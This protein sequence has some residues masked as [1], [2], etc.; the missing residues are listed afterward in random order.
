MRNHKRATL[1]RALQAIILSSKSH[2]F[3]L[4]P[5]VLQNR[6]EIELLDDPIAF[7]NLLT[8][9]FSCCFQL[10]GSN[11]FSSMGVNQSFE[12]TS[13]TSFLIPSS[14]SFTRLM[15]RIHAFPINGKSFT[16]R[17]RSRR[18]LITLLR[19]ETPFLVLTEYDV[20]E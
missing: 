17:Q 15:I 16:S 8:F 10:S 9:I 4:T 12:K 3:F 1:Y 5:I 11:S 6:I 2:S 19:T 18:I 20:G 7:L 14:S 13:R